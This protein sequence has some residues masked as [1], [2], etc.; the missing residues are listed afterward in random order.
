MLRWFVA[1][2]IVFSS[3]AAVGCGG[4]TVI[5]TAPL[6]EE[7]KKAIKEEDQRVAEEE[8]GKPVKPGKPAPKR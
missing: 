6:T 3:L 8:G 7:Q 1:I 5:N 4:G 2:V